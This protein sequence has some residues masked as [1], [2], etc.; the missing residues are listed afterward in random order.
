M[1]T[2][3]IVKMKTLLLLLLCFSMLL[4]GCASQPQLTEEEKLVVQRNLLLALGVTVGVVALCVAYVAS[5]WDIDFSDDIDFVLVQ[6][7][8]EFSHS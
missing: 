4:A 8:M 1:G 5:N 7:E 2:E 3:A 6:R